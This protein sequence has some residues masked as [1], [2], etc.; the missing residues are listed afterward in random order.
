MATR[1][2]IGI[3]NDDGTISGIYCHWDGYIFSG[4]GQGLYQEYNTREKAQTLIDSGDQSALGQPYVPAQ[5][6]NHI[7]AIWEQRKPI[8]HPDFK[9]FRQAGKTVSAQYVYLF[10]GDEWYYAYYEVMQPLKEILENR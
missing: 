9:D 6:R 10:E 4:V 2:Y 8:C 7:G 3:K 1:S 5:N